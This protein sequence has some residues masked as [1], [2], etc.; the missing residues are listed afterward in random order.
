MM[1]LAVGCRADS[2]SQAYLAAQHSYLMPLLP[3]SGKALADRPVLLL[4]GT[5]IHHSAAFNH[6]ETVPD[7]QTVVYWSIQQFI[8]QEPV[9][10]ALQLITIKA[11]TYI[12]KSSCS[13]CI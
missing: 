13:L 4:S 10:P 3:L 11:A 12:I 7:I 2:C 5:A 8:L 9:M 6:I 1:R